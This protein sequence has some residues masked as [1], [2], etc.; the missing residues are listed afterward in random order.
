MTKPLAQKDYILISAYLDG[1]L[2]TARQADIEKRL[3]ADLQFKHA[4]DDLAYTKRMLKSL[5]QVRARRNFV[6]TPEQVKRT[7]RSGRF[8]PVWGTVSAFSTLLLIVVFATTRFAPSMSAMPAAVPPME[9]AQDTFAAS[10]KVASDGV[11][12]PMIILWNPDRA[13]GMGGGNGGGDASTFTTKDG[14]MEAPL[15]AAPY[16]E[17]NSSSSSAPGPVV[18]MDP[19]TLILGL[20]DASIQ[21]Q[22]ITRAGENRVRPFAAIPLSTWLMAGSGF[23]ALVSAMLA[24][25]KRRR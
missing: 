18:A 11:S 15:V 14:G 7:V 16:P 12:T 20:P 23:V 8:Q 24:I 6:L 17:N 3:Q 10:G 25:L 21:G 19:S 1:A 9:S 22:Q 4:L 2:S 13:F 5:P